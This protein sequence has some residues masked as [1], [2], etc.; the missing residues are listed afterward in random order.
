MWL[1]DFS[2]LLCPVSHNAVRRCGGSFL[3]PPLLCSLSS[4]GLKDS[5]CAQVYVVFV[6]WDLIRLRIV[7]MSVC[8]LVD[9]CGIGTLYSLL[10]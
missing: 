3:H 6:F 1:Y 4:E 2:L 7:C 8:G 9:L 5:G 10:T